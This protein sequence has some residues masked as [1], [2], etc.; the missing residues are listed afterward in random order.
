MTRSLQALS[1]GPHLDTDSDGPHIVLTLA[2][3]TS[4]VDSVARRMI[5][6]HTRD[7]YVPTNCEGWLRVALP[8]ELGGC[9]FQSS[10]AYDHYQ[11]A[12][13][14]CERAPEGVHGVG[15]GIVLL[16]NRNEC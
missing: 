16:P 8:G 12:P 6:E 9:R 13:L 4:T 3:E 15:R 14:Q 11:R 7:V 1:H 2:T 5:V 10:Q